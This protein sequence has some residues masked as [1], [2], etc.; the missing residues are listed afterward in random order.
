ML[1][2][3]AVAI[4]YRIGSITK[5]EKEKLPLLVKIFADQ[6]SGT[7]PFKINFTSLALYYEGNIKYHWDFGDNETS[8]EINPTHLYNKSGSYNCTL[9][10]TGSFGEKSFDRIEILARNN[11]APTVSIFFRNNDLNPSRPYI[12]LLGKISKKSIYRQLIE[13][14]IIPSSFLSGKSFVFVS[15]TASDPEGD[16]IV[17]YEWELKPPVYNTKT[18]KQ[19]KPIYKLKEKNITIPLVYTLPKSTYDLTLIVTDSKGNKGSS[20]VKFTVQDSGIETFFG[21]LRNSRDSFKLFTW[22]T[23]LKDLLKGDIG[24][25]ITQKILPIL[26]KWP[27][28][29][30]LILYKASTWGIS[31]G[32]S[33]VQLIGQFLE[34]HPS[35]RNV[36]KKNLERAQSSLEKIG[37]KNPKLKETTDKLIET[38]QGLLEQL[39]LANL[40]P[41]LSDEKPADKSQ[42]VNASIP[43]VSITVKDLEGDPFNIS[44]HGKYL[45]N[46]TLVNQLNKTFNATFASK[47]PFE[48]DIYWYVNVSS[49]GRWVNATYMFTT[50]WS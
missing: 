46:I 44:I 7:I 22:N 39:G 6:T 13:A 40:K 20:T 41:E 47:L 12:P 14:K 9:T 42:L 11:Q 17:S 10:I 29:T 5:A 21:T 36:V 45:N 28:L 31:P 23:Y 8:D 4:E 33:Y 3:F 50:R 1:S 18:G 26:L 24:Q 37:A 25:F 48:T 43:Q 27:L 34:K 35:L 19:V 16:E 15:G 38:I 2:I 32:A 30:L 49:Q